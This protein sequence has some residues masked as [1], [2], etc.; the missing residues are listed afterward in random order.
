MKTNPM[1]KYP[2][3]DG[4]SLF[5]VGGQRNHFNTKLAL[6]FLFTVFEKKEKRTK[7]TNEI[8]SI[9]ESRKKPFQYGIV[10]CY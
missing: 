5:I 8:G 7:E 2:R 1:T 6:G 9:I 3:A 10:R 4:N